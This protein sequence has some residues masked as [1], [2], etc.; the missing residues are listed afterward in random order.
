[1]LEIRDLTVTIGAHQIVSID[2]LDLPAGRRLGIVGESG[3]GKTLTAMSI[4]GLQPRDAVVGGSIRFDGQEIV[5]MPPGR[6]AALRGS[7]I[8][9]V[10]QDPLRALNPTMRIG[11]QVAEAFRLHEDLPRADRRTRVLDL[12]RQVQL[13]DPEGLYRRYPHQLSG[14]QRQRVLIAIA[15]ACRPKLLI[16][17]EPTTALDVTVQKGILELLVELSDAH[18]MGL[19]FV[20]HDLGLADQFDR[21]L[22]LPE[23]NRAGE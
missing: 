11:R 16:A 18:D 17:D 20:S 5:G 9:V 8:G 23:L 19:L 12:L 22:S 7:Q 21:S 14:G 13:R 6:L 1:M 3:S 4:A 10:F 15:I 2:A